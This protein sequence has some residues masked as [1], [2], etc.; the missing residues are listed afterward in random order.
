[1]TVIL[2]LDLKKELFELAEQ[3]MVTQKLGKEFE[4]KVVKRIVGISCINLPVSNVEVSA[5]WYVQHL[6]C[7]LVREPVRFSNGEMN[8]IVKM[9]EEGI[10]VMLHEELERTPLH[11]MR[12][13]KP[14][15]LFELRT[16]D[17]DGFYHQLQEEGVVVGERY[18]NE[19]CAKYFNVC[20]PDGN[21]ISIAEWY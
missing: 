7:I 13:G 17:I 15:S 14:A 1:M 10:T 12:N 4:Q 6:G 8:A 3:T 21:T 2:F 16:M 18:D 11:F 20:D 5:Q 19:P 9:G